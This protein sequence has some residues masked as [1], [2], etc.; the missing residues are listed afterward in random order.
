MPSNPNLQRIIRQTIYQ[1][2]HEYGRDVQVYKLTSASTDRRTGVKTQD[3]ALF[4]VRK[5]VV[6]PT[7]AMRKIFQSI[8][9]ISAS[10]PFV[11]QGGQGWDGE[12]TSFIFEGRD[13][14]AD[15]RW[16]VE[17][18]IVH[19]GI[20]YDVSN[21][22]HLADNAGWMIQAKAVLGAECEQCIVL[23]IMDD[24]I[25]DQE[26]VEEVFTMNE[27]A[28]A[29]N[30][31]ELDGQVTYA[32]MKMVSESLQDD[33]GFGDNAQG[34]LVLAPTSICE[35]FDV[36][37]DLT[38]DQSEID[39]GE[40]RNEETSTD[41]YEYR[42]NTIG[43]D[44]LDSTPDTTVTALRPTI[45]K[46]PGGT[47]IRAATSSDGSSWQLGDGTDASN[48]H[49]LTLDGVNDTVTINSAGGFT[50]QLTG[51]AGV[52]FWAK[53][54][55]SSRQFAL[56]FSD[57]VATGLHIEFNM[58][59]SSPAG[60]S[61]GW[62]ST[63]L[64]DTAGRTSNAETYVG[65]MLYDDNWHHYAWVKESN[66]S[67]QFYIDGQKV[68]RSMVTTSFLGGMNSANG[69]IGSNGN[70]NLYFD[71]QFS[72]VILF[73][74]QPTDAAILE[75]Y[76]K[77][78]GLPSGA[79]AY[80]HYPFNN[81]VDDSSSNSYDGTAVGGASFS[82]SI[83]DQ[84]PQG[85]LLSDRNVRWFD[86]TNDTVT[87]TNASEIEDIF[88]SGG[89][90]SAWIWLEDNGVSG[91]I[92]HKSA[93][94]VGETLYTGTSI[95]SNKIKLRFLSSWT[96]N[97]CS[98][99]TDDHVLPINEWAHIAVTYDSGSDANDPVIYVNGAS[100]TTNTTLTGRPSGTHIGDSTSDL[101]FASASG[102][103]HTDCRLA[104]IGL[105]DSILNAS[106]IKQ[107]FLNGY[108]SLT[109]CVGYWPLDEN[110]GDALDFVNSNDGTYSGAMAYYDPFAPAA[111]NPS[112]ESI[113]L[114]GLGYSASTHWIVD[115]Q[116]NN[117]DRT[118]SLE[119]I[120]VLID[121]S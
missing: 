28:L 6:M 117:N 62:L 24:L 100:K 116:S 79:T 48:T 61:A 31:L 75:A 19:N 26:V 32:H 30:D 121:N 93:G 35:V 66:S 104:N 111:S 37:T 118:P 82:T 13:L 11:S 29:Q 91:N 3:E 63:F 92:I 56:Q 99:E 89:T 98:W 110:S 20:R 44:L 34:T 50:T 64:R 51:D 23:N 60:S 97:T 18:W 107:D 84:P 81:D 105:Y 54:S 1:L 68:M 108:L 67:Q 49:V 8:S 86:G 115:M 76:Q 10:K 74:G 43:A 53:S 113:S 52:S 69:A 21:I 45:G 72:Q 114:S 36:A 73:T 85:D 59:R 119:Q 42:S 71:G 78:G 2:K 80:A 16:E 120:C 112:E 70:V 25:L 94:S 88:D 47:L 40:L 55:R 33:L 101:R 9:Y 57:G 77:G 4:Q 102:L 87:V 65:D 14:P 106:Q 109:D 103:G 95:S 38:F 7:N 90:W 27:F 17:D 58:R 15:H 41:I 5:C 46:K 12:Q 83:D 39:S 22:E 96:A